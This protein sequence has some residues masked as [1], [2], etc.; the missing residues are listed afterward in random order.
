ML[1]LNAKSG[2]KAGDDLITDGSE[3]TFM[4]EMVRIA[5]NPF[6]KNTQ[7]AGFAVTGVINRVEFGITYGAPAVGVD[8]NVPLFTPVY[9]DRRLFDLRYIAAMEDSTGL[10]IDGQ[11]NFDSGW[12]WRYWLKWAQTA[13]KPAESC[14]LWCAALTC[15]LSA[16]AHGAR[17]CAM[18]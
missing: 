7:L 5:P 10:S 1:E 3:A 18:H 9:A 13:P 15:G 14:G 2:G 17:V 6:A 12:T 8:I 16:S 11:T 4:A